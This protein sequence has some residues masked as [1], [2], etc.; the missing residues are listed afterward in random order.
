MS[1]VDDLTERLLVKLDLRIHNLKV[2]YRRYLRKGLSEK[3]ISA[4][5]KITE[6]KQRVLILEN[7][8]EKK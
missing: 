7:K 4:A 2:D 1:N 5:N 3:A 8:M 6:L